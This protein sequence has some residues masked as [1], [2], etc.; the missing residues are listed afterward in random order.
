MVGYLPNLTINLYRVENK[1]KISPRNFPN[2]SES[3]SKIG[4]EIT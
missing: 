4:N 1:K 2:I 3:L